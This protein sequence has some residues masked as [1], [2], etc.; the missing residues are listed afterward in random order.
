MLLK[1]II[2]LIYVAVCF[3]GGFALCNPD[4]ITPSVVTP[5]NTEDPPQ[6]PVSSVN[7]TETDPDGLL[8]EHIHDVVNISHRQLLQVAQGKCQQEDTRYVTF[9]RFLSYI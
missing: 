2:G 1:D 9:V 7:K 3:A 4:D 6:Q 8:H 5:A